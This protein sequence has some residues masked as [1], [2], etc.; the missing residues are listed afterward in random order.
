[1]LEIIPDPIHVA[2]LSV[3]FLV[4]VAG[5]H[6]ILWRPMLAYL[7][8][9]D[10]TVEKA[11]KEAEELEQDTEQQLHTLEEKLA[12]ARARVVEIHSEARSRAMA[13]EAEILAAARAAAEERVSEA[14]ASIAAER[15][16]AATALESTAAELSRDIASQVLGRDVA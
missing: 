12:S 9:R 10:D 14:I 11:I 7:E 4:A 16:A 2:L 5:S 3:P 6:V 15:K 8:G 13:K 1:M